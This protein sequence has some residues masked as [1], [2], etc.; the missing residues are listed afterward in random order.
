MR[1]FP[2]ADFS[3]APLLAL[4]PGFTVL[5]AFA[6]DKS[7]TASEAL[8]SAGVIAMGAAWAGLK[9]AQ[10]FPETV[11]KV[12][13]TL[14]SVILDALPDPVM[15]LDKRRRVLAANRAADELLGRGMHGRDIILSLRQPAAQEA[16]QKTV[17]GNASRAEAD[18]VFETPVRRSYQLQ[19]MG[20][21]RSEAL[22]VRAVVA[23]HE[24]TAL[25]NAETMRADFVANVSHELRSPLSALSGFIETLQTSAKDDPAAQERFLNIMNGEA[26][27]MARLID[28]LLSLSRIEVN[29]HIRP[30]A[31]TSL[32]ALISGVVD[33][34][35]IKAEQK[36]V[37]LD[38]DL[39]A[40]LPEV[41]GD[42]DELREVFQNLV[43]N[44][45]KY[46]AP[47]STVRIKA[48]LLDELVETKTPGVEI[49]VADQ[50]DGI[51]AEHIPR[52]TERFYRVD[53]GRSRSMGG[54]GLGLAIV[55]HIVNRHRGRLIVTSE[56][57]KG[58]EF[59][60]Q[61]PI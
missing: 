7:V 32:S 10:A 25:K 49:A 29:E 57:G 9:Q 42:E 51:E 61:L 1:R 53:K 14:A 27:R 12:D 60:V 41:L 33:S 11:T 18:V 47:R 31:R 22:S 5:A 17:A 52:L 35:H 4:I 28:D 45:I 38:V 39:P 36:E 23:L 48:R 8:M 30:T 58:S 15:L 6:I 37:V 26:G 55:K 3:F 34:V 13:T 20:V 2:P 54:T 43:D 59:R 24:V 21:P 16:L 40:D 19:V 56:Q 50:G 44:A 46:G